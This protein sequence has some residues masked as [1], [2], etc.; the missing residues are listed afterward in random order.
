MNDTP[1][2]VVIVMGVSGSGKSTVALRLARRCHARF[3]E[4]DDFHSR[5]NIAKMSAGTALR[6]ADRWPWLERIGR[7]AAHARRT[8]PLVISCSALKWSYRE[9]LR[10]LI[11]APLVFVCLNPKTTVLR[12]R[13]SRRRG[14]F[15]NARLLDSQLHVLELPRPGEGAILL[16]GR[17]DLRQL[18]WTVEHAAT[19]TAEQLQPPPRGV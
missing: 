8:R 12:H 16:T 7:Y 13:L 9:R 18:A 17:A 3:V 5:G 11:A 4:G 2:L 14:H 15:M 10:L 6:D 19:A 1:P